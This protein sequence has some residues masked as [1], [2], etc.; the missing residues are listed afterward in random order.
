MEDALPDILD[1]CLARLADGATVDEC[2]AAYPAHQAELEPPLRMAARVRELPR[3]ALPPAARASLETQML[4]LAGARR[5][6][7]PASPAPQALL[8]LLGLDAILAGLLRALGYGGPLRQPWL[9][10]AAAAIATVLV[11]TLGAGTLVAARALVGLA[12]P[13][14]TAAPTVAPSVA[15]SATAPPLT[16]IDGP[17]EQIAQEGWV[18]GGMTV[19]LTSTT[20]V[21]GTPV[22]GASAHVRGTAQE[23]GALL[24]NSIVVAALPTPTSTP[25]SA[26]AP[27]PTSTPIFA[28]TPTATLEP[29]AAPA[30]APRSTGAQPDDQK[31]EC[32][33]QQ[34]GRDDKKCDPKP[35]EDKKPPKPKP[36]KK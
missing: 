10:L 16:T 21:E 26:P 17:I 8:G 29:A 19:V 22:L 6:A 5:A 27:T 23:G 7:G 35:H 32:Q 20:T 28:P 30:P 2:L 18:V 13:Q 3:P 4:A 9:R 24:A 34:R 1:Q 36:H 33:G 15:P 25:T 11:L 31:R 12:R 14:P